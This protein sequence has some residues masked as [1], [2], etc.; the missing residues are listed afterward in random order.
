MMAFTRSNGRELLVATYEVD[1]THHAHVKVEKVTAESI[2]ES[3]DANW[4][5]FED[6]RG[7]VRRL[8]TSA[9]HQVKRLEE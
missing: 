8:K 3:D 4:L 5:I 2:R 7:E 1:F 9:V 6:A